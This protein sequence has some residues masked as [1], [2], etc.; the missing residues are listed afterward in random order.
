MYGAPLF[1]EQHELEHACGVSNVIGRSIRLPLGRLHPS[2]P[3]RQHYITFRRLGDRVIQWSEP[4]RIDL[5]DSTEGGAPPL[6]AFELEA[7]T[8]GSW[9]TAVS[10]WLGQPVE[11]DSDLSQAGALN[12]RLAGVAAAVR[13]RSGCV[14][15][16]H[17]PR[18]GVATRT[19]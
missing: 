16:L 10:S 19:E 5:P 1:I 13:I 2:D 4:R 6:S 18:S 9:L 3:D 11:L 15:A 14:L 8:I 17:V 7:M 12:R